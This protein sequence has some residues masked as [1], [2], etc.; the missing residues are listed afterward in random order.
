[1][2][3]DNTATPSQS[4]FLAGYRGLKHP[5]DDSSAGF[6]LVKDRPSQAESFLCKRFFHM[7]LM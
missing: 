3:H 5:I 2:E 1:M 4:A 6:S 7:M